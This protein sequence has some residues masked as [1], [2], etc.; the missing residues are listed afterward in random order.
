MKPSAVAPVVAGAA[1]VGVTIALIVEIQHILRHPEITVVVGTVSE[2]HREEPG[3]RAILN[4]FGII[5]PVASAAIQSRNGFALAPD[6]EREDRP[7]LRHKQLQLGCG[8][9]MYD[10]V[11]PGEPAVFVCGSDVYGGLRIMRRL[12]YFKSRMT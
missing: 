12:A 8:L 3:L 9:R 11:R 10:H 4:L 6:G 7:A 5:K 1:A 2:R